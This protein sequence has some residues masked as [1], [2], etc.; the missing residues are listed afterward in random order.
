MFMYFVGLSIGLFNLNTYGLQ[1]WE[2]FLHFFFNNA[3]KFY[4]YFHSENL[5][6]ER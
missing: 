4:F 3:S 6:F 5:F 1:L 2:I